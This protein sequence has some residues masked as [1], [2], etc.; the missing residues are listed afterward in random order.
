M[1]KHYYSSVFCNSHVESMNTW[2]GKNAQFLMEILVMKYV[3]PPPQT[4]THTHRD[5]ICRQIFNCR[6]KGKE[7]SHISEKYEGNLLISTL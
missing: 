4:H 5:K 6:E 7:R 2:C 3:T 1:H